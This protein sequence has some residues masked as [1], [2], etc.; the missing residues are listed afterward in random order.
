MIKDILIREKIYVLFLF[1]QIY[2]EYIFVVGLYKTNIT[3]P[4]ILTASGLLNEI[5]RSESSV[6]LVIILTLKSAGCLT[7]M[8]VQ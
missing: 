6:P 8:F 4:T 2:E 5:L 1:H 7:A 3:G